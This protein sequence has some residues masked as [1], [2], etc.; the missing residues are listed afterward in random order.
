ML[1]LRRDCRNEKE[2]GFHV[3]W[4]LGRRTKLYRLYL[5]ATGSMNPVLKQPITQVGYETDFI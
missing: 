2:K 3:V 1:M 5:T 4:E